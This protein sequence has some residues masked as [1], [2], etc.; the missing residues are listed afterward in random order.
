MI[1][2]LKSKDSIFCGRKEP[3]GGG[4]VSGTIAGL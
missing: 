2:V 3:G 4:G 1:D